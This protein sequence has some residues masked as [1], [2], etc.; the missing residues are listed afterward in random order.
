MK[1]EIKRS[2]YKVEAKEVVEKVAKPF[3]KASAHVILPKK[4]AGHKVFVAVNG[5]EK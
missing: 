2:G 3:G 4:W 1:V 5:K